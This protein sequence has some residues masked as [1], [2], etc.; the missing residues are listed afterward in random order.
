M[1]QRIF[2]PP[3]SPTKWKLYGL[4]SSIVNPL[5]L[6]IA[7]R[8]RVHFSTSA[9]EHRRRPL[10]FQAFRNLHY[11]SHALF[12]IA[13]AALLCAPLSAWA[14]GQTTQVS[15][16]SD[17]T[18]GNANSTFVSKS[19]ISADG[20]YVTFESNANNLVSDDTNGIVDIF[21]HDRLT[22]KTNRISV[23][24]DGTQGY[25]YSYYSAISPDGRYVVFESGAENL[26][27]DDFNGF[28]DTFIHDQKSGKTSRVS[29]TSDGTQGNGG[30]AGGFPSISIDGRYIVFDSGA[31][32]LVP[33][34]TNGAPDVF[35]H[36]RVNGKTSRISV[37]SDGTQGNGGSSGTEIS[38]DGRYITFNSFASN[39]VPEDTNGVSDIFVHDRVK[40]NTT[41]VR[42]NGGFVGTYTALTPDRRYE[43]FWSPA[44]VEQ[45]D[46]FVRDPLLLPNKKADLSVTQ[47]ESCD[48]VAKGN[49]LTYTVKVKNKGSDTASDVNLTDLVPLEQQLLSVIPSQG[50]CY[51][52]S[53]TVCRLGK[54]YPGASAQVR[55]KL[56]AKR[57]GVIR[58]TAS[59][60][61]A[62][63]D[64]APYN[65]SSTISTLIK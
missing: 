53:I 64:L 15:V 16:A 48:P 41:R 37:A 62:P 13:I 12:G 34:D 8:K 7:Y 45:W 17:G 26:V 22:G 3:S 18:P 46:I 52:A 31:D 42:E 5:S 54:L 63:K 61:A 58:N 38:P 30:H 19:V 32:N 6:R 59:V 51:K 43:A 40:G 24:S 39:L 2:S 10:S 4:L 56:K 21:V 44:D 29:I 35:V 14:V 25:G 57:S 28:V 50:S 9:T 55:V 11:Y 33:D 60:N 49:Q 47:S 27:P 36:D 1:S 23:A 65:N 20:R